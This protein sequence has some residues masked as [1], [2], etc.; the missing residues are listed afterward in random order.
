MRIGLVQLVDEIGAAGGR[1]IAA[2]PV[3]A[4]RP[5]Q[6]V[7]YRIGVGIA[8]EGDRQTRKA[9][10]ADHP[11]RRRHVGVV[12][13]AHQQVADIADQSIGHGRHLQPVAGAGPDFQAAGVYRLRGWRERADW[14]C[15]GEVDLD[16]VADRLVFSQVREALGGNI[17]FF[18]SGGG[19]LSAELCALYHGMGLP[20]LEG[21][22]LTET[23]PVLAVNPPED[24]QIGTI[25]YPVQDV[26]MALDDTVAGEPRTPGGEVG[27]LLVRG[28]NV[29]D[30]YW[31]K[32]EETESSFLADLPE[33][34]EGTVVG[35]AA[36]PADAPWFRTGDIVERRTDGF[37][38]F[39]ERAK[40]LL[41]LSTGKNVA[42][43]PI[44]DGFAS[45]PVVEQC[46]VVGDGQKFVSALVVPNF[47]GIRDWASRE[48]IDLPDDP[49][50]ICR[51]D[52]VY[53]RIEQEVESVNDN[54]E[55][56]EQI[57]QFRIVP[58][59]FTEENDLMTPTMKKKRRHILEKYA[60]EVNMIY[61]G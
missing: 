22:G 33:A 15:E 39:R 42:P 31:N 6:A 54:F 43:G 7:D 23:A 28:P 2:R 58:E 57:K 46:M 16:R 61:Q 26:E 48:G 18:I 10:P 40:Q 3:R 36:V 12:A 50:A 51:H 25:G 41:V 34:A 30:G 5:G 19:S 4:G 52:A 37:L 24:P 56:Y 29:S 8:E 32:P 27:E 20:I 47:D 44:E 14:S 21:Y 60:D 35:D 1:G 59:E 53:E 9:R 49:Q 45:S 13:P 38:V 17:D 55:S 11:V